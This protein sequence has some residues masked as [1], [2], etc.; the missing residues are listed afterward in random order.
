[1]RRRF[2]APP[3]SDPITAGRDPSLALRLNT[4]FFFRQVGIFL[5][6]DLLLALLAV[7]GAFRFGEDLRRDLIVLLVCQGAAL[8]LGLPRGSRSIRRILRPIQDLTAAAGQLDLTPRTSRRDLES[9]TGELGKISA[10]HLDSRIDLAST[11]KELRPLAQAVNDMLDRVDRAYSAQARF[12][13]DASH[14]LRTP[15]AV[16]Q[17][18]AAL[19]DRWGKSDPAALQESIEAIRSEAQGMERLVEQLLFLARGDNDSQPVKPER[20]DLTLLAGDMVR[21]GEMLYPDRTFL[22]RWGEEPVWAQAD[23][24]LVKQVLRILIDNSVKYSAPGTRI[25]LRVAREGEYARVA[26]QDEGAGVPPEGLPHIFDRFYRSDQS[27]DRRTGGTGL[28]LSIARWIV[29]R[30]GGWFE[31]VSWEE[32]GTRI[33]FLLP[34]L[35]DQTE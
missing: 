3:P 28:G 19:L 24:G 7:T 31:V 10:A 23:P 11:Q 5:T 17:G 34:L 26:V 16:I 18:Y 8:L 30:H 35:P 32:I 1:M 6:M 25:Y 12:V 33:A 27:R 9:L 14:E 21:E 22:P 20:L 13:S 15:I 4:G 29:E 2:Q